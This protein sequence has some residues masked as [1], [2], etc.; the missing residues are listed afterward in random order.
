MIERNGA[1]VCSVAVQWTL[2]G[3][4]GASTDDPGGHEMPTTKMNAVMQMTKETPGTILFAE[5]AR[6]DGRK[7]RN[8]YLPKSDWAELGSPTTLIV[9]YEVGDM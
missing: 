5:A 6:R 7:A 2:M 4:K 3:A 9:T 1:F 8:V